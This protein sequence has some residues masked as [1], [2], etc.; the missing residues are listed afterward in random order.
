MEQA[1]GICSTEGIREH[2]EG[3][4][5]MKRWRKKSLCFMLAV[6]AIISL[7]SGCEKVNENEK[8]NETSI[9]EESKEEILDKM[10]QEVQSWE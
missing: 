10:E 6:V 8:L 2:V 5:S 7:A 4:R 9:S 3:D 1:G